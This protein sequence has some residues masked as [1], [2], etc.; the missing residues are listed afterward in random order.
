MK[1]KP[2]HRFLRKGKH[3]PAQS[4]NTRR[5]A[6]DGV[7][8]VWIAVLLAMNLL[9]LAV[10]GA[11]NGYD[12]WLSYR[13]RARLDSMLAQKGILCGSS[14]YHTLETCPQ[15]YTL[16]TDDEVQE[17]FTRALL[18]GTVDTEAR[19]SVTAWNGDNGTV[20]WSPSGAVT[21]Q[22]RLP[23]VIEPQD[24]EQAEEVVY[25]LL[26]QA[27]IS[28]RRD[29]IE[30]QE[31]E[32]GYIVTVWQ[33]IR[34]TE[35]AGC[36]LQFTIAPGNQFTIEGTWCTGTAEP[37]T[38]R[39]LKSYSAEQVLLTFVQSQEAV[40][41]IISVQPAYVLSDRSGGRF[42]AIPC[43]RFTTDKGEYILNILTGEVAATENLDIDA[44][45]EP[46]DSFREE[47]DTWEDDDSSD[48]DVDT[49]DTPWD[50]D[51]GTG[52]DTGMELDTGDVVNPEPDSDTGDLWDTEG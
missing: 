13:T 43:W 3:M 17:A 5:P 42:T 35:L 18:T 15:A 45:T 40:G 8:N 7:K 14:V 26:K 12:A 33:E 47:L 19:G 27:G 46:D 34:R 22:V 16:R 29:Q 28:V 1:Q 52:T 31:N 41:Q 51:T 30:T 49:G 50:A 25:G 21:A 9:L 44:S 36:R 4:R 11:V 2:K 23:A 37:M 32:T 24:T 48:S 6:W 20:E 39:A 10:L 38:I